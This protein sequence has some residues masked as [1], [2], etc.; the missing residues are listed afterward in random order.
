M[1]PDM[2][3]K[4]FQISWTGRIIS[5]GTEAASIPVVLMAGDT[6]GGSKQKFSLF[7][8]TATSFHPYKCK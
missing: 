6:P 2:T 3:V 4:F 1:L 8:L 5:K 7:N